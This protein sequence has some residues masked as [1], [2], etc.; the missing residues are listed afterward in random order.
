M[1]KPDA[2]ITVLVVDDSSFF[3]R[4]LTR[5]L[6]AD[7]GIEVIGEAASAE[8]AHD[9]VMA[10]RP[11]VITLDLEMPGLGGMAFLRQTVARLRIPTIVVSSTTQ[12]GARRSIEAL[13]AGAVDVMP[14]PQG[15]APGMADQIALSAIAARVRAVARV[16]LHR[17]KPAAVSAPAGSS[18]MV[19]SRALSQD[20]V[21]ALGASTGGVQALGTVLHALPADCPP[22]VIVQHMPAGFTEAFARRLNTTCAIEVREARQGDRLSAGLALIAPGGERHMR[23]RRAA[24]GGLMVDLVAGE[25]VCFSL[26]SVD[27]LLASAAQLAAPRLSAAILTGM[28]SDGSNGLLAARLAGAQTFVQDEATSLVYG[29]PARAWERGAALAQVPLDQ[30]AAQLLASVGTTSASPRASAVPAPRPTHR[31]V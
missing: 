16:D 12:L 29:M 17:L 24:Q 18:A 6:S 21:I 27:V 9:F 30:I 4:F 28:G 19:S 11:D 13:E 25:P 20:W 15:V 26:P 23:L 8:E 2:P 31:G 22:V 10:R 3:R 7:P 1:T 14:K 5:T